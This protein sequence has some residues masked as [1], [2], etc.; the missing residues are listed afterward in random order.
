MKA[1]ALHL[2]AGIA[3]ATN[4]GFAYATELDELASDGLEP[5][6]TEDS[7]C[8]VTKQESPQPR[9]LKYEMEGGT[10]FIIVEGIGLDEV[11]HYTFNG[12]IIDDFLSD[13]R[14][15]GSVTI[16]EGHNQFL[17]SVSLSSSQQVVG[18]VFGVVTSD[19]TTVSS[20]IPSDLLDQKDAQSARGVR[21]WWSRCYATFEVNCNGKRQTQSISQYRYGGVCAYKRWK[22]QQWAENYAKNTL[23]YWQFSGLTGQSYC[24]CFGRDNARV[25]YDTTVQGCSS[26]DGYVY[27]GLKAKDRC[28]CSGWTFK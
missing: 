14:E 17:I 25:Y 8:T 28:Y 20:N 16:E 10:L 19:G 26:N 23:G 13:E 3:L 6:Q 22:C 9:Q 2:V 15:S 18:G 4:V 5:T 7:F 12:K 27:S 24:N 11:E 1:K 21:S